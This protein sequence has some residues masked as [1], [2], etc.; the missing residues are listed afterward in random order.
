MMSKLGFI[1]HSLMQMRGGEDSA[2]AFEPDKG[3]IAQALNSAFLITLAGR[4]HP[5]FEKAKTYLENMKESPEWGEAAI[6][7]GEG[8][9]FL[10]QEV[11][12][13]CRE[14]LDFAKNL[15]RLAEWT[16]HRD[17]L[18]DIRGT[19]EKFWAVFFPEA[20]GL[21]NHKKERV[22]ELR[23]RRRVMITGLNAFPLSDPARQL[24]FSANVLLT[25]PLEA[26]TT[27]GLLP[28]NQAKKVLSGIRKEPQL[29]WYDHPIP[30]GV[31]PGQNEVLHGLEGLEKALDFE[32]ERGHISRGSR[33]VC[34]LSVS[35]THKGLHEL[36][37][38]Y[39][40][41]ELARSGGL[42]MMDLYAF[43]EADIRRITVEILAPAGAQY[44]RRQD[45]ERLLGIFGVDGEYGRHYSF[46]KAIAA[47]WQVVIDPGIKATFK[48]DLDQVF[49]Q[50][51]LAEQTGRSA[52][53]HF[54]T[55]LWGAKGVDDKGRP[56]ELG[57]I[58]GALVNAADIDRSLFSCDVR[59]PECDPSLD[60]FFFFSA[61]PQALSTEA[62]MMARYDR[63][64]LDGTKACLQRIHV[65]GGTNGILIDS[66]RRHRPFTPSFIGRAEDQAYIMSALMR[67][68]TRLAYVHEDGLIMRHDKEAFAREAMAS[69]FVGKLIGDYIRI[70][71]FSAYA[72]ALT[73]NVKELKERID[74]FTGCFVSF[75]PATVVYL[76][77]AFKAASFF[78]QGDKT[79][80]IRFIKDGAARLR[81]ALDFA[82][83]ETSLLKKTYVQERVGWDLFYEILAAVED[84]IAKKEDFALDLQKRARAIINSCAISTERSV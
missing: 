16:V 63:D 47:F 13:A 62:E 1:V 50:R 4:V 22:E 74:P 32:R 76:R 45:A 2:F 54:Q 35:V 15:D 65:T 3:T 52:F 31:E 34:I 49:P 27:H 36:A 69:A 18:S 5:A 79:E 21:L 25:L 57:M 7:Y 55:P 17:N 81:N 80:G 58:A 60:E 68:G 37:R 61:L 14:D 39:I 71:N 67:P 51:E 42:N 78:A 9:S 8:E 48:I 64:E 12:R 28:D 72:G 38:S 56:V 41:D 75:I 23:S 82:R 77:F 59:F 29:F 84:A 24:L 26:K 66:L 33:P 11:G 53:E 73:D 30:V 43:T 19:A 6:F 10:E 46:L 83:G 20:I 44:L 40:Q 70:I